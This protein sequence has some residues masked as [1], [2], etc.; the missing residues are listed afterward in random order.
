MRVILYTGKGGVGKTSV[1]AATA[2]RCAQLGYRT[3]VISTD[4]AH[5]L[6]DSLDIE[7][8]DKPVEVAPNL[9]AQEVNALHEL[10]SHWDRIHNY[11]TTLFASQGVDDI[12]AEELASPPGMEEVASLMWIKHHQ[13]NNEFDVL[14]VDC[15][16]TGE[17]LQLLA[18]PDVAR[19]YLNKI[20]PIERRVMKVAR[21]MVQPFLSIPLPGDDIFGSVKDLLIDLEGM[22]KV[23]GDPKTCTVR[24]V[25]NLEKMVVKE[26][27]RAFTYLSL[28]DYLT[29]LVVVNRVLPPEV[30]DSYFNNWRASQQRYNDVVE[31]AFSPIPIMRTKLFDH[32]VVGLDALAEMAV[33]IFGDRDPAEIYYSSVPQRI[34][35]RG[36][37]Y[38]LLLHLPFVSK[39]EVELSVRDD[40]LFV[41]VGPYKREITL[42][43]SLRGRPTR[44]AR[45][46]EGM[47]RVTF[48][49]AAN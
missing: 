25:L 17:T 47:L 42:P 5:S 15:A 6:G 48:G 40:E 32:E 49:S 38:E 4:A 24:L 37:G 27:Q 46:E 19:W 28:Y 21:P 8:A 34:Q 22:K 35:K 18:F 23:L 29:D 45:L 33:S 2:V 20:F 26:A 3:L 44:G 11:L 16:P 39:D 13:R 7:V 43:K 1:A 36:D 10:E 12:V 30:T 9:W 31:N 41:T 14:V